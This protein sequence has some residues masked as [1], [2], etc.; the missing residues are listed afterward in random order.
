MRLGNVVLNFRHLQENY[1]L[2]FGGHVDQVKREKETKSTSTEFLRAAP[3]LHQQKKKREYVR[4]WHKHREYVH[5]RGIGSGLRGKTLKES[6]KDPQE[7]PSGLWPPILPAL[8]P[9]IP[10]LIRSLRCTEVSFRVAISQGYDSSSS[11]YLIV[12]VASQGRLLARVR[13]WLIWARHA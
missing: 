7:P 6:L 10:K 2:E 5:T 3:L 11:I 9:T 1:F 12:G 13:I 4:S 8:Q